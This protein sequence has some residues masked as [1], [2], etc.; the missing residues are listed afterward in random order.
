MSV[1]ERFVA[2]AAAAFA[3][4]AIGICT[5]CTVEEMSDR[6]LPPPNESGRIRL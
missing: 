4:V 6:P 5:S 3:V 2:E 1:A